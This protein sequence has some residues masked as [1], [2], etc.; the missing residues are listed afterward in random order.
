MGAFR[1]LPGNLPRL[2]GDTA[3]RRSARGR[4]RHL[5]VW[6]MMDPTKVVHPR[7][8]KMLVSF[9]DLLGAFEF[10]SADGI[11]E[12]HALRIST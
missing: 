1:G 3:F 2:R 10:L 9:K 7:L 12:H 8:R 6:F 11:S 4:A 5:S